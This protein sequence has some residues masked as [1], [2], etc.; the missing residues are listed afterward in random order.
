MVI[1]HRS[2]VVILHK[3]PT[4]YQ[5]CFSLLQTS[6][7]VSM[8][9]F[10]ESLQW[11]HCLWFTVAPLWIYFVFFLLTHINQISQLLRLWL[12]SKSP[13]EFFSIVN[14]DWVSFWIHLSYECFSVHDSSGMSLSHVILNVQAEGNVLIDFVALSACL[15]ILSKLSFHDSVDVTP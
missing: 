9:V 8:S 4:I 12:I 6:F 14:S 2:N 5:R 11:V 10:P 15:E 7:T 3:D 13:I 1:F